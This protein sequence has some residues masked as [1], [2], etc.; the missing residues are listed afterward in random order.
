M[1]NCG[2]GIIVA[3]NVSAPGG[4]LMINAVFSFKGFIDA[5]TNPNYPAADAGDV[6][7]FSVT[8]KI[9]GAGGE[10]VEK[11]DSM[12]CTVD[13]SPAGDQAAVGANWAIFQGN[14]EDVVIGPATA[15]D[16]ALARFDT[17]T[18]KLIQSGPI[19]LS[20]IGEF[21]ALAG[22]EMAFKAAAGKDIF[23][24]MGDSAGAKSIFFK[25]LAGVIQHGFNSDGGYDSL[26]P[27]TSEATVQGTSFAATTDA[28]TYAV[29]DA[30]T[31]AG[32]TQGTA[33]LIVGEIINVTSVSTNTGVKLSTTVIGKKTFIKNNGSN[34]LKIYPNTSASIDDFA[35]NLPITIQVNESIIVRGITATKWETNKQ[36]IGN[37]GAITQQVNVQTGTTYTLVD[38]DH[39][40]T[41]TLDNASDI[42]VSLNTGLRS[43]FGCTLEQ[44][45]VG[46][47]TVS[48]T[49]TANS[50]NNQTATTEQWASIKITSLG[51]DIYVLIFSKG[52][53]TR[54][55]FFQ[56]DQLEDPNNSSWPIN[57]LSPAVADSNTP[58]LN[59]RTMSNS[60]EQGWGFTVL[61]PAG[62]TSMTMRMLLRNNNGALSGNVQ[63]NVY[64]SQV[65]NNIAVVAFPSAVNSL[66]PSV[67]ALPA[68]EFFQVVDIVMPYTA[69]TADLVAGNYTTFEV[70]RDI[71]GVSGPLAAVIGVL[72]IELSFK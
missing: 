58:R 6:F 35:V 27:I 24:T 21:I 2:C 59:V 45:G 11:D 69:F 23:H 51:S 18:G 13:G 41:V 62:T 54:R 32:T 31:A 68:N 36:V 55:Y 42:T 56:A 17:T 61:N 4:S 30:V 34:P 47:V 46:V 64:H 43:D 72:A 40:K 39:G 20:N 19:T 25:D 7:K 1:S 29:E 28:N 16:N 9:G 65:I 48:G 67:I 26:G 14:L 50:P 57:V 33:T 66:H 38:S 22:I 8:G 70:T 5:S 12:Y 44:K 37:Q 52:T 49:A 53:N 60:T 63:L 10:D 15:T 3:G 71:V